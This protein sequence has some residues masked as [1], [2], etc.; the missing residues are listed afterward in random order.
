MQPERHLNGFRLN[1]DL[2]R[3]K[4]RGIATEEWKR[5]GETGKWIKTAK[6]TKRVK[7]KP[8]EEPRKCMTNIASIYRQKKL[9]EG[10]QSSRAKEA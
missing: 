3:K 6:S 10:K 4:E 9:R 1:W 8:R 5:K 2:R 7:S